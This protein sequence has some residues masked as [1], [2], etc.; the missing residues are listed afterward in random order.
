MNT[1]KHVYDNEGNIWDYDHLHPTDDSTLFQRASISAA[2]FEQAGFRFQKRD[3]LP[4]LNNVR[5]FH[6]SSH[7]VRTLIPH[8]AP[9]LARCLPNLTKIH[10]I[11]SIMIPETMLDFEY[12]FN[13]TEYT[14]I[15][16]DPLDVLANSYHSPRAHFEDRMAFVASLHN[17]RLPSLTEAEILFHRGDSFDENREVFDSL[18]GNLKY[19]ALS[20]GIRVFSQ[21]LVTLI[22]EGQLDSALFW[23]SSHEAANAVLPTWPKLKHLNVKLN[24]L[25]PSGEW[26]LGAT[27]TMDGKRVRD[28]FNPATLNPVLAALGKAVSRMPELDYLILWG[29]NLGGPNHNNHIAYYAPGRDAEFGDQD[30]GDT[31]YR[32]IYYVCEVGTGWTPEPETTE[33]LKNAGKWKYGGEVIERFPGPKYPRRKV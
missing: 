2:Q 24:A 32:R 22:I 1:P 15:E 25:T 12:Y 20:A 21:N 27:R 10:W 23:P 33:A 7:F 3:D 28:F 9:D 31:A 17:T 30:P 16:V 5:G 18:T 14:P 6:Q 13:I 19:D 29:P 4:I 11:F 26:Y 8:A